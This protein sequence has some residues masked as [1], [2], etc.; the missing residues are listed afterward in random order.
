[1]RIFFLIL[2][3]GN[4]YALGGVEV[5]Y[6]IKILSEN[7]K[8]YEQLREVVEQG[9]NSENLL[10]ILNEGIDNASGLLQ[11]L[12]I[13]DEKILSGLAKFQDAREKV[14][15]IYGATPEGA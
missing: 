10:R 7:I 5:P 3:T 12:P 1:M 15:Q 11:T 4:A 6:L 13:K 9:K 8:Q 14:K 2:F